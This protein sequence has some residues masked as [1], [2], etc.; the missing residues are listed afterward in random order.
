MLVEKGQVG[1]LKA[2]GEDWPDV[3][4]DEEESAYTDEEY[5]VTNSGD[6]SLRL[7]ETGDEAADE[8][9]EEDA[10]AEDLPTEPEGNAAGPVAGSKCGTT[11]PSSGLDCNATPANTD[12]DSIDS[13]VEYSR[14]E[15]HKER[16][17]KGN[18]SNFMMIECVNITSFERNMR[19]L[20]KSKAKTIFF[21]EHKIRASSL[22]RGRGDP[23][24]TRM[25]HVVQPER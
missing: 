20:M 8:G 21:Q 9:G 6:E 12:E 23:E 5:A 2:V 1:A 22:A 15:V 18:V 10:E 3:R 25:G 24:A 16:V 19:A 14:G 11:G 7:Q 17:V 4:S 13:D